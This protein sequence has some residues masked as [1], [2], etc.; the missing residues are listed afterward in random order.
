M[1]QDQIDQY[2]FI[3]TTLKK[4]LRWQVSDQRALMLTASIYCTNDHAF[5][6]ERFLEISEMIKKKPV[7]FLT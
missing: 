1:I 2:E 6:V 5:D 4:R 3:Y 7:C